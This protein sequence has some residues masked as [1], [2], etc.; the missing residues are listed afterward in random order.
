MKKVLMMLLL[1]S[2]YSGVDAKSLGVVG[3]VF[4]I[5]ETSFLTLIEKRLK[6]LEATGALDALNKH[7]VT[8]VV[9][10]ADRPR[11]LGLARATQSQSHPY[12]PEV[13]LSQAIV[14]AKGH[15]LYPSGTHVNALESLPSYKPCWLFFD[16]EDE[17]Q[18]RWGIKEVTHCINPKI[19]LTGGS[20]HDAEKL[21]NAVIYFDQEGRISQKLGIKFVPARVTRVQ[22]SLRIDELAIK[23]NGDAL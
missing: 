14:D 19:I 21:L 22:N 10:H 15:I 20:V 4:P 9:S 7:W 16:A 6:T 5:E 23:E 1:G 11:P 3:E 18:L 17:A 13:I 2:L 12:T 8:Q